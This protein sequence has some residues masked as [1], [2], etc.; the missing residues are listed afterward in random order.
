MTEKEFKQFYNRHFDGLRNYL[1]YR[2]GNIELANDIAQDTF[3]RLWEKQIKDEGKRTVGLAYKVANDLFINKYQRATLEANY[4]SSLKLEY[5][6]TTPEKEM[7]YKELKEK[8]EVAL[9][10]LGEKQ[11]VVFLMSRLEGL[12]YTEI[13]ERLGISVKAVEKRM[14]GALGTFRQVLTTLI[15]LLYL[16]TLADRILL[17]INNSEPYV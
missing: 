4:M 15:N 3:V 2:S 7:Q 5:T 8:Y 13:A 16:S 9:A 11:R 12:K 1:Y 10:N 6:N 14:N 17:F